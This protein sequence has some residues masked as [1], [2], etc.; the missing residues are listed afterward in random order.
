MDTKPMV[1]VAVRSSEGPGLLTALGVEVFTNRR[2]YI[3]EVA[4]NSSIRQGLGPT[5]GF[6]RKPE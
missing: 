6:R 4:D 2:L 5:P 3:R 1:S